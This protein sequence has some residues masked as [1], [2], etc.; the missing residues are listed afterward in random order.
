MWMT[1]PY[2]VMILALIGEYL[3]Q[4]LYHGFCIGK[5]EGHSFEHIANVTTLTTSTAFTTNVVRHGGGNYIMSSSLM[6]ALLCYAFLPS[7]AFFWQCK[8][9]RAEGL[10]K[11][12]PKK[13]TPPPPRTATPPPPVESTAST[14]NDSYGVW[15]G[16]IIWC[17]QWCYTFH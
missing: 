8:S 11:N 4:L 2:W 7:F 10:K 1:I 9:K 3:Y 15:N 12:G 13:S 17:L 5:C 6:L 16:T 14:D